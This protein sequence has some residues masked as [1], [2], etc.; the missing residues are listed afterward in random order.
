[1]VE[2]YCSVLVKTYHMVNDHS[3]DSIISWG[4]NGK[5]F[6]VWNP[7]ELSRDFLLIVLNS[8]TYMLCVGYDSFDFFTDMLIQGHG[9]AK[10]DSDQQWE[11]S[12]DDF[13]RDKPE[14]TLNKYTP[15]HAKTIDMRVAQFM[16]S[17]IKIMKW[18][19]INFKYATSLMVDDPS[20]DSIISWSSSGKSFIV[21]DPSL[22]FFFR[23]SSCSAISRCLR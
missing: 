3:S 1:M 2:E 20:S 6:I 21:W 18:S 13:I 15:A 12:K 7:H 22:E 5:S 10:V 4:P 11:F 16:E 9:F 19:R 14:L 17:W 8:F 23:D